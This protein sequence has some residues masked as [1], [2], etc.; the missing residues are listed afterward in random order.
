MGA[1]HQISAGV[2]LLQQQV[3]LLGGMA[4]MEALSVFGHKDLRSPFE[5]QDIAAVGTIVGILV[6]LVV[7]RTVTF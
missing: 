1:E 6:L 4:A 3:Q 5:R 7:V 2:D